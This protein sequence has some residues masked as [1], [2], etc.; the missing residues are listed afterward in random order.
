MRREEWG[1]GGRKDERRRRRRKRKWRRREER[2]QGD[3]QTQHS[4]ASIARRH[5]V[6]ATGE[7]RKE[8]LL[9]FNTE[10][11]S[12]LLLRFGCVPSLPYDDTGADIMPS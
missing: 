10:Q 12:W 9:H 3:S 7:Q 6:T 8:L 5:K 2:D 11:Q 4:T 1:S